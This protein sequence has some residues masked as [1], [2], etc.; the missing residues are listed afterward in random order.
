MSNIVALLTYLTPRLR[1]KREVELV[2][3]KRTI[4]LLN[5][6]FGGIEDMYACNVWM[7]DM[8]SLNSC[9]QCQNAV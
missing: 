8:D 5:R 3:D 1:R 7:E 4:A 9:T 6:L 2:K